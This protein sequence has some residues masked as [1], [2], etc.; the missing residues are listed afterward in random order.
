LSLRCWC[1]SGTHDARPPAI[2]RQVAVDPELLAE[3]K[4]TKAAID[5]L[6]RKLKDLVTDLRDG[7]ATAQEIAEALRS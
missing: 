5:E 1:P 7:G 6:Q 2:V 4:A 3:L